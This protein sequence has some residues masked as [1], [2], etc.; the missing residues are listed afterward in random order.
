MYN[1]I[2]KTA[3]ESIIALSSRISRVYFRGCYQTF[4]F[5]DS[6]MLPATCPR[7]RVK[8]V[9]FRHCVPYCAGTLTSLGVGG[10]GGYR[11]FSILRFLI[12]PM[13][14]G[15]VRWRSGRVQP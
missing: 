6:V 9:P 8:N 7:V 2:T 14:I 4:F 12:A 3:I 13:T 10:G 5:Q 11:M 15:V 1:C